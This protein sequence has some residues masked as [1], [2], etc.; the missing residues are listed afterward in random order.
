MVACFLNNV[1]CCYLPA[2]TSHGLQPLD[3][4][5]FNA[6]KAAYRRELGFLASLT[7]S[8]PVDKVNFIRAYSAAREGGL[9]R[10]NI[11]AGWRVTGNWP[12]S[13]ARA[14]RHPE[15]QEDDPEKAVTPEPLD[16]EPDPEST[17]T[18]SRQVKDIAKNRSPTTR[19]LI[20]KVAKGFQALETELATKAIRITALE[21]ELARLTR[22]KKRRAI[23]NPNRRFM[24]IGE[25]LAAGE[26]IPNFKKGPQGQKRA[27]IEEEVVVVE[28]VVVVG[29]AD[30]QSADDEEEEAPQIRTR[31]GRAIKRPRYD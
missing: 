20:S 25:A 4:G 10:K 27:Q 18:T 26:P 29:G 31:S 30:M 22:S 5:P 3:N 15:I 2:H 21:E 6:L 14:L 9:T 1:F 28:D 16:A 11:L 24:E 23:P 12:I 8:A 17:P 13:R 19:R 7:D